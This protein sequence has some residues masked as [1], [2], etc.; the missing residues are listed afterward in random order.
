VPSLHGAMP[1]RKP[2]LRTARR[3]RGRVHEALVRDLERL[4][5]LAAGGTPE[6]PLVIASPALV[7]PMVA[8]MGCPLCEGA[9]LLEEHAAETHGGDRLRVARVRCVECGTRR[10]V[11]FRLAAPAS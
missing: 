10:E 1:K 9:F 11:F 4:A 8:G 5:R 3:T 6:R 2:S 7:D